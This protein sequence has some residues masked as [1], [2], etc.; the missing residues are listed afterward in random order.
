MR[1]VVIILELI[2][3]I[4][5]LE[6]SSAIRK[7]RSNFGNVNTLEVMSASFNVL[8]A[9]VWSMYFLNQLSSPSAQRSSFAVDR[10]GKILMLS[11]RFEEGRVAFRDTSCQRNTDLLVAK[12]HFLALSFRPEDS[13]LPRT[14]CM[15][16]KCFS[17]LSD[18]ITVSSI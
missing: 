2:Y 15:S 6:V 18:I 16:C 3:H 7:S 14:S 8:N 9:S 1:D 10:M 17:K 12:V 4:P 13:N 5:R 11:T